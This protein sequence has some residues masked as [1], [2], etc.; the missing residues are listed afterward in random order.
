[1]PGIVRKGKDTAGG[2]EA[3]GS[4]DVIANGSPVVRKGD[5]VAGHGSGPHAA[6]TMSTASGDVFANGIG[7][8]RAGD[9]ATCGHAANGSGDVIVN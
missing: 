9:A 3:A 6:P 1:M 7:V 8:C 2:T 4:P 5:A